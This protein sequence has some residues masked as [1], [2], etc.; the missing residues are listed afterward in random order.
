MSQIDGHAGWIVCGSS[1]RWDVNHPFSLF[2]LKPWMFLDWT[3]TENG[4]SLGLVPPLGL[5][6]TRAPPQ[7]TAHPCGLLNHRS[8]SLS[9]QSNRRW[10][11][12]NRVTCPV[13]APIDASEDKQSCQSKCGTQWNWSAGVQTQVV[14]WGGS[15]SFRGDHLQYKWTMDHG[16]KRA[17]ID[18][19]SSIK[20]S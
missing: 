11:S 3:P 5:Q 16:C 17:S 18:V 8:P 2:I 13:A 1:V 9:T 15:E 20:S 6:D 10:P 14:R 12:S 4:S 19:T 7:P